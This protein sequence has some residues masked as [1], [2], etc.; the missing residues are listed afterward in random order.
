MP[1]AVA[2]QMN[3]GGLSAHVDGVTQAVWR[4][5]GRD[6]TFGHFGHASRSSGRSPRRCSRRPADSVRSSRPMIARLLLVAL[7]LASGLVTAA[8]AQ[9]FTLGIG[10]QSTR[11]IEDPRFQALGV[12]HTRIVVPY[13]LMTDKATYDRYAYILD[14]LGAQKDL[15]VLVAFN[16]RA[17]SHTWLPAVS[18]Y[19][20]IGRT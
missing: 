11:M 17:D 4:D 13:N 10:D 12:R 3:R 8:P 5:A 16:H 7:L 19:R 20:Q 15:K 2:P 9:A 6:V 14:A 18:D 1:R